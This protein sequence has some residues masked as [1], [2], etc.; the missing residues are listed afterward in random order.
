MTGLFYIAIIIINVAV[1]VVNIFNMV[2]GW[3][4]RA[5]KI[6]SAVGILANLFCILLSVAVLM[7]L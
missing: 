1:L 4:S 3:D 6:L 2:D 7:G 5:I